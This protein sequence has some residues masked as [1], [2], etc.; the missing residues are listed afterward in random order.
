VNLHSTVRFEIFVQ[1]FTLPLNSNIAA[2]P[3]GFDTGLML[4]NLLFSYFSQPGRKN[5][6]DYSAWILQQT[7]VLYELFESKFLALW[8]QKEKEVDSSG[9]YLNA[10][11]LRASPMSSSAQSTASKS[12]FLQ[13]VWRDTLGFAGAEMIRR[14]VGIAHV[15][16]LDGIENVELRSFCEKRCL[17]FARHCLLQATDSSYSSAV[18]PLIVSPKDLSCAVGAVDQVDVSHSVWA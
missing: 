10:E 11:L 8:N 14:I 15:E 3:M 5:N 16:D 12:S 2:G 7:T 4:A 1:V 18:I 6:S 9:D 17:L 13:E